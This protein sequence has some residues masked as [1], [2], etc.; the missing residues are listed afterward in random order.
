MWS[1]FALALGWVAPAGAQA[2]APDECITDIS[3]TG[4]DGTAREFQCAGDEVRFFV[5]VPPGCERGGCGLIFDLPGTGQSA[6]S[7]NQNTGLRERARDLDRPF[8]VV[9]AERRLMA[10]GSPSFDMAFRGDRRTR[11]S[12]SCSG[13]PGS[14]RSI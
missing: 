3:P 11:S 13:R 14:L 5:V 1:A 12:R 4:P 8:I 6:E 9:N 10:G 2:P 7:V